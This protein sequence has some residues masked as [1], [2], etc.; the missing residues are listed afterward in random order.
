[1]PEIKLP[2]IR[3]KCEDFL[4]K[5]RDIFRDLA[6]D[7]V[8][9]DVSLVSEDNRTKDC[10]RAILGYT[11]PYFL[12]TFQD[13][14]AETIFSLPVKYSILESLVEYVYYGEARVN[15]LEVQEFH[16][17]ANK[18]QIRGLCNLGLGVTSDKVQFQP[19]VRTDTVE[20]I[21]NEDVY[22]QEISQF[23]TSNHTVSKPKRREIKEF[24]EYHCKRCEFTT[25]L[26]SEM[27]IHK[28]EKHNANMVK[29]TCDECGYF[30]F[31]TNLKTHKLLHAGIK[32]Y[33]QK[34]EY[35]TVKPH[36]LKEHV[37][38]VH[39][40]EFLYCDKCSY[41]CKRSRNLRL[42]KE[43]EHEGKIYLCD[44]CD[45]SSKFE[46]RLKDH[47]RGVHEGIEYKCQ[48][49]SFSSIQRRALKQHRD[50]KHEKIRYPCSL[51][52][53]KSTRAGNLTAHIRTVHMGE[54]RIP[55]VSPISE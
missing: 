7:E 39:E 8:F 22:N 15:V 36:H 2:A 43:S 34:C 16:H 17:F 51:C 3:L 5:T 6:T 50:L 27:I 12:S 38:N 23:K 46:S 48:Q 29:A 45:F 13:Q 49:C 19:K 1:M 4:E 30:G 53:Y 10:H 44:K 14:P 47:E 26:N 25:L 24:D 40:P 33:C 42:H 35:S 37:K 28:K 55:K 31:K 41:E 21:K 52:D 9:T 54:K 18:Y 20:N 32:L 11:S